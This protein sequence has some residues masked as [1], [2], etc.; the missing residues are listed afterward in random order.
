[1]KWEDELCKVKVQMGEIRD[2]VKGKDTKNLDCLVHK[3]DSPFTGDVVSY[4]LP[5]KFRMPQ[6]ESFDGSKDPLDHLESFKTMMCLQGFPRNNMSCFPN[7][8]EG[9]GMDLV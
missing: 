2:A 7:H 1:M 6:L 5:S 3:T 8:L 9:T 4:L